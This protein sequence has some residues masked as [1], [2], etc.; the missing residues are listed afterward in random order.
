V[1]DWY[2]DGR[3]TREVLAGNRGLLYGDGLFETIAVRQGKPRF[4]PAHYLRL[5][6]G[7]AQLR[8]DPPE[9]AVLQRDLAAALQE[10]GYDDRNAVAKI[11]VT[12]GGGMRG[13][14]RPAPVHA[15]VL[16][17]VDEY[18]PL[19]RCYYTDGIRTVSCKTVIS[20]Q[21]H[22]AGV[23]TLNRLDQVI[24]RDEFHDPN[25]FEGLMF[26]ADDHLICGTMSN[27]FIVQNN[28]VS[29]P[30]LQRCGIAGIMREQVIESA[31]KIRLPCHV[32]NI[33]RSELARADEVFLTNS[34]FGLLPVAAI[35][36]QVL[37]IGPVTL[38]CMAALETIG[39]SEC[40]V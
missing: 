38:Q 19:Q 3:R 34:Q 33:G 4:W 12:T 36:D 31:A 25:I 9:Q 22:V 32:R 7:C 29:T 20:Q 5:S 24:A 21:P 23:K 6:R 18:R 14:R 15:T 2:I 17:Q 11:V 27:V 10:S 16:I 35:D 26:D 30:S 37:P 1:N 8:F 28:E 13:Y 40:G 39:V